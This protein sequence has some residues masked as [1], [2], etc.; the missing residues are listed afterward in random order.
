MIKYVASCS[1]TLETDGFTSKEAAQA[2]VDEK[3]E[4]H[5]PAGKNANDCEEAPHYVTLDEYA[6]SQD[7][8]RML[9]ETGSVDEYENWLAESSSCEGDA[10]AQ[11]ASLVRVVR[12]GAEWIEV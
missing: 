12:V 6:A 11:L 2:W 9:P 4:R 10:E 7:D 3:L 8:M 1:L 5:Y